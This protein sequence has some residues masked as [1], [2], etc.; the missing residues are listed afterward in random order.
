[1]NEVEHDRNYQP[2]A[3]VDNINWGLDNSLYLAKTEFNICFIVDLKDELQ[4]TSAPVGSIR[5][6]NGAVLFP[7]L[8]RQI[9][10]G[11]S[12]DQGTIL[13]CLHLLPLIKFK[14]KS[15]FLYADSVECLVGSCQHRFSSIFL[16]NS[17]IIK[18]VRFIYRKK[19][20]NFYH[21]KA[22]TKTTYK[23]FKRLPWFF[24]RCS[25]Y[26]CSKMWKNA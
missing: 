16:L 7:K 18:N 10:G 19:Y 2:K 5:R 20:T 15:T 22:Y 24:K 12:P 14:A 8:V 3:E 1:L 6:N 13:S 25:S 21:W 17:Y 23:T 4:K 9:G 11:N 26:C